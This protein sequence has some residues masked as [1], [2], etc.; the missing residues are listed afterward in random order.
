VGRAF[1]GLYRPVAY[2]IQFDEQWKFYLEGRPGF[3]DHTGVETSDEY[4]DDRIEEITGEQNFLLR[5]RYRMLAGIVSALSGR[6]KRR[7]RRGVGGRLYLQPKFNVEH[8]Q[9]KYCLDVGCGAGRWTRSLISLGAR[10]KS[11]DV[12]RNGLASTRRFNHDV[13]YPDLFDLI[14]RADLHGKFEFCL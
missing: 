12:S 6:S 8:F 11:M 4:I 14:R 13:E 7:D 5:R 3:R 2:D 10:V 1:S 9:H